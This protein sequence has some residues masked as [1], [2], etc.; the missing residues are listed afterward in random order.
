VWV[1]G[2]LVFAVGLADDLWELRP[3]AKLV[4]QV[5]AAALLLYAGHAFWRG[6]PA[7]ASVPLTF[8][9]VI[10]IINAVNLIDGIDGLAAEVT[11][12]AAGVLAAV[13]GTLGQPGL[14]ALGAI[15]AGASL[16]FLAYN[17]RP[18]R[19]FMG[20]SGS[21]LLGYL[22]AVLALGAQGAGGPIA[23]TLVP[24]VVLAV[25]IFDTTFVT[26]TRILRGQSVAEGGNDHTHHRLVR[27]GLSEGQAVLVLAGLS[28]LFG[29]A[30]LLLL[31]TTAQLFYAMVL[32][33]VVGCV[34]IGLYLAGGPEAGPAVQTDRRGVPE[35][36]GAVMQAVAGGSGWKSV[37][38]VVADVVVVV[39]VLVVAAHLRFGG[40]PPDGQMALIGTA[41]PAVATAKVVVFYL[42]GLY[43]G[44]WRHAGTPE[45]VR[46]VKASTVAS[47][48]CAA[49]LFLFLGPEQVS[50]ALLLIDWGIATGAVGGVRFG[51]RALRQYFAAQR[52][53][54][55]RALLYG[56]TAQDLLAL[57]HLRR[58]P[59][60]TVVGFLDDNPDRH[61]LRT[62]GVPVL[63]GPEDLPSLVPAHDVDEVVV[64]RRT[65]SP[66]MRRRLAARC[67]ALGVDCRQFVAALYSVDEDG[68]P[69]QAWAGDGVTRPPEV[70]AA[71]VEE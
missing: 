1:G 56:S 20:D 43:H 35:R 16:G 70:S 27:L 49:G 42:F 10:G 19:I 23:G 5:A 24:V 62:Q 54:G 59:D 32:L 52:E 61:G 55:R 36:V 60:H 57:R 31:H 39:A 13:G 26:I 71:D 51:F 38:G 66:A 33:G 47:G 29:V 28:G 2:G 25:P 37:V 3:E 68:E 40:R 8:L 50:G 17:A 34:G 69:L 58:A 30:A 21:L 46:V 44:I 53:D 6:G 48:V 11:A 41:L 15:V 7:W 67:E 12:V 45:V 18:A 22:L 65:V 63:G 14:A 9:W 64:P 4:A